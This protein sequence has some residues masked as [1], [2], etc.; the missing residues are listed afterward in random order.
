M[1][2]KPTNFW[3]ELKRRKVI[4]VI[5]VYA[6]AA[7]VLLEL[8]DI[9]AEPFGLPDWTLRFVFVVLLIGL[10]ISVIFSWV[11]DITPEGMKKTEPLDEE[12]ISPLKKP[13]KAKAWKVSTYVSI[14]VILVL[15]I[16]NI[17]TGRRSR[18]VSDS[19]LE[20]TIAVLPFNNLSP[21]TT[22]VYFCEGIRE[23]ILNHL[24]KI[25]AFSVRSRTSADHYRNTDKTTRLIGDELNVNYLVEGSVGCE[26]DEIKVWVQLIDAVND[27][28][29]WSGDFIK[30]RRKIFSL[31]SE[32]AK[33]IASELEVIMSPGE[34]ELIDKQPTDSLAAYHA[35]LK[36]RYY[37]GQPHFTLS[38]WDSALKYFQEAVE[39]DTTF[40]LAYAELAM[41]HARLR[42]L[43][44]D[45]SESRLEKADKAAAK[46]LKYGFDQPR[47]HLS[48]GYYFLYAYRDEKQ[49]LKHLEIAERDL[50]YN[51]EIMVEKA[52]I[53]ITM[54]HWEEYVN[55]LT[56]AN[57][58]N[59]NDASVLTDLALG[60]W[61]TK[62]YDEAIDVCNQAIA[63]APG[64]NWPYIYKTY[65]YWS[66]KGPD[67]ESR[68][69]LKFIDQ[70]HEWWLFSRYFQE[71]GENNFESALALL[72]DTANIWGVNNKMWA[73]PVPLMSAFIYD[74]LDEHE[75]A[76]EEYKAAL[77][78]LKSKVI[79][80]PDDPRYHSALGIA[81]AGLGR[82]EEAVNEGL[83]AVSLL[84]ISK[85]AEYGIVF[86]HDLAITYTRLGEYDLAFDQ[87]EYLLKNPGWLSPVWLEWEIRF[88]PLKS[89]P[90]YKKLV[91][92][93]LIEE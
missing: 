27:R 3:Q 42:Y 8:V 88:E 56:K 89:H 43:R 50:P 63:L 62:H 72:S 12:I 31:Q 2:Q 25:D 65:A 6:A 61:F 87:I 5:P 33:K 20:K 44:H 18:S 9:I 21:D 22:Q 82:K 23:E 24:Q 67:S 64:G 49:A 66:W 84:P 30:E 41:A 16:L 86:V 81:Y 91:E 13:V 71:I 76:S 14:I 34:K 15:I 38:N 78:I 36:G 10:V 47:V 35:Y 58:V 85:D 90:R 57:E 37:A 60:L 1:A 52:Y 70:D 80:V 51:F 92:E 74:Y 45:L 68:E 75:R 83:K 53:I 93:Y 46:A 26:G 7:F 73:M 17:F 4:R 55:L 28:H 19:E 59:P 29:V 69:S 40:A 39:I 77:E 48:L 11:Y 54:G 32:I 79:E